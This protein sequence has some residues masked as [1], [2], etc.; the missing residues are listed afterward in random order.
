M[1]ETINNNGKTITGFDVIEVQPN[2]HEVKKASFGPLS[3]DIA[4]SKARALE[5]EFGGCGT[6]YFV[7]VR[8]YA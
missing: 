6:Y 1:R 3:E 8:R 4:D 5:N 7:R 2:G